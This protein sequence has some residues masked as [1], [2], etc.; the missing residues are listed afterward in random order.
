MVEDNILNLHNNLSADVLFFS[1]LGEELSVQKFNLSHFCRQFLTLFSDVW[2][3][4]KDVMNLDYI[5]FLDSH[6]K[7]CEAANNE[8][9]PIL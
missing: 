9:L 7:K 1:E 6:Y 4:R 2:S 8:D 5:Q 3:Y